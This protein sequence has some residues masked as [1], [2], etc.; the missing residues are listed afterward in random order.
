MSDRELMGGTVSFLRHKRKIK[1][2][3]QKVRMALKSFSFP[4][5]SLLAR[6]SQPKNISFKKLDANAPLLP[7]ETSI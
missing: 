2:G 5:R 1:P 3:H 4:K 6:K 7:K